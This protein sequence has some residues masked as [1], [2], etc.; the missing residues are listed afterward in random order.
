MHFLCHTCVKRTRDADRSV[1]I[2]CQCGKLIWEASPE[3]TAD[4]DSMAGT[5]LNFASD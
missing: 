1:Y 5:K 2:L 4:K 3:N